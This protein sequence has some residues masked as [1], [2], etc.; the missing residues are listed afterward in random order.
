MVEAA[1]VEPVISI[2]NAQLTDSVNAR[3]EQ[4]A[5]FAKSAYKPRTNYSQNSQNANSCIFQ[6]VPRVNLKYFSLI[7][8]SVPDAADLACTLLVIARS[9]ESPIASS[10]CGGN[11]FRLIDDLLFILQSQRLGAAVGDIDDQICIP[12]HDARKEKSLYALGC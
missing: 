3:N 1:G 2:E 9:V 5:M 8:T 12:S 4:N 6:S 10:V 11:S 7:Y